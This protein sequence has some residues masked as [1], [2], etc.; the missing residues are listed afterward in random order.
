M[1]TRLIIYR[2]L[3]AALAFI[4]ALSLLERAGASSYWAIAGAVFSGLIAGQIVQ[5]WWNRRHRR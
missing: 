5:R 4:L 1:Q 2:V 3:A